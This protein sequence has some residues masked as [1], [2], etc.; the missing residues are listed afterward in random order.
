MTQVGRALEQ[1]EAIHEHLARGEV[2][3]GWRSAPVAMSGL[4][5]LAAAAWQSASAQFVEPVSFTVYWLAV[6]VLA[7]ALGCAEIV[8]HYIT[9]ASLTERR[10]SRCV[11]SQ[12]LP[13]LVAGLVITIPLVRLDVSLAALLPGLWAILFG[14]GVFAA[15]PYLPTASAL[16]ACYYWAAGLLLLWRADGLAS[17]SPWTVGGVF[18][19]GQLLAAV[20]LYVSLERAPRLVL[21]DVRRSTED[22]EWDHDSQG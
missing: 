3:R 7:L 15:R 21:T 13:S 8:W 2:Y 10:R 4:A 16:V 12:F 17:L 5:G 11:V 22:A 18:G 1:I 19:A 6:G 9:H 20:V 14:V